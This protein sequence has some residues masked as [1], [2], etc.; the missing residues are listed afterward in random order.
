MVALDEFGVSSKAQ[1][2]LHSNPDMTEPHKILAFIC[3]LN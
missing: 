1:S 3:S 2:F